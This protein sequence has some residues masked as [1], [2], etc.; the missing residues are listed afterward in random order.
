MV[1][2]T[3]QALVCQVLTEKFA[4]SRGCGEL[5]IGKRCFRQLQCGKTLVQQFIEINLFAKCRAAQRLVIVFKARLVKTDVC[6]Q[7]PKD[8]G[9]G[10]GLA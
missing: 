9:V 6:R 4:F 2:Q 1:G 8:L 5:P 10:F 3:V 7:V